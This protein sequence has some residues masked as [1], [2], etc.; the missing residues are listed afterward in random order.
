MGDSI[1][2][3]GGYL[4]DIDTVLAAEYPGLKLPKVINKGISGQ[5]AEDLVPRSTATWSRSSRPT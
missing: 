1:A 5:H 3:D 4:R 2:Q